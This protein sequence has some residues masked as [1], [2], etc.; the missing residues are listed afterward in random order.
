MDDW[1]C[2]RLSDAVQNGSA[3]ILCSSA[4]YSPGLLMED[5]HWTHLTQESKADPNSC[6]S[7]NSAVALLES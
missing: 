2:F 1:S 7:C 4:N 3:L 5:L 6:L